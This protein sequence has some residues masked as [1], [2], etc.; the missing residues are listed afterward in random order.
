M[1]IK[2]DLVTVL[3]IFAGYTLIAI[4]VHGDGHETFEWAT[5]VL[6]LR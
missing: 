4:L 2:I 1:W 6:G 5:G 3:T